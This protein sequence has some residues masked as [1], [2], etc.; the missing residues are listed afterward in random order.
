MAVDWFARR[1]RSADRVDRDG[2]GDLLA[3]A[4]RERQVVGVMLHHEVL[5]DGDLGDLAQLCRL[6][7]GHP[8]ALVGSMAD[9]LT[10]PAAAAPSR[11]G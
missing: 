2:R 6:L 5:S 4:V 10:A 11:P 3:A 8:T 7:A 9:L 1:P